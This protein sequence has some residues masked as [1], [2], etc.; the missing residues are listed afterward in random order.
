MAKTKSNESSGGN[1][2]SEDFAAELPWVT[3]NLSSTELAFLQRVMR[4]LVTILTPSYAHKAHREGYS[5]K[6]HALGWLLW[7]TA[8]GETRPFEDW[9]CEPEASAGVDGTGQ[10]RLL[11]RIDQFENMWFP[12]TRAIIRRVVHKDR[13]DGFAAAF[14]KDLAQQP[15]G[16]AVVGSVGTFVT[17]IESLG[18]SGD[19]DAKQVREMLRAR[20]LTDGRIESIKALLREAQTGSRAGKEAGTGVTAVE[21]EKAR[22]AQLDA[23]GDLR[24]W[25]N[26]WGTTL[27]WCFGARDQVRLGLMVRR[28]G[29]AGGRDDGDEEL[30]EGEEADEEAPAE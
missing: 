25:F 24:D 9:L 10:R 21:L 14:F 12:R 15:L 3:T 28:A 17:R 23:V 29:A 19:G 18:A 30:E 8:A 13:R 11:Q 7:R 5:S 16:P 1:E 22:T 4:F 27:R 20:G 26:D 2:P 6:E